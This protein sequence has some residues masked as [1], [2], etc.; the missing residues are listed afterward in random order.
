MS[1]ELPF[2]L[3]QATWKKASALQGEAS[4]GH[5]FYKNLFTDHPA[6]KETLFKG[7]NID[8]QKVNL[9]KSITTV[10]GLLT[11]MPKAVSALQQL[12][13]RHVAYD[14][15]D[16]GYAV[17]GANVI[18]TL[19]QILGSDF[20][21]EA[22]KEWITIYGV[23]EKTMIDST[24]SDKSIPFWRRLYKRRATEF[25]QMILDPA[26][27]KL[28]KFSESVSI[29]SKGNFSLVLGNTDTIDAAIAQTSTAPIRA[30]GARLAK[31]GKV[32]KEHFAVLS[33][34]IASNIPG[35]TTGANLYEKMVIDWFVTHLQGGFE[36][37]LFDDSPLGKSEAASAP[38]TTSS[39]SCNSC[40]GLNL[41]TVSCVIAAVG[42]AAWFLLK[43]KD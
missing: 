25:K 2:P 31:E 3:V 14:T 29:A 42:V 17:V 13:M 26:N 33:A 38:A 43:K 6:L 28:D 24:K 32:T 5:N 34:A 36:G 19:A 40:C 41:C 11:D 8:N 37:K 20:T 30:A 15:P 39:S 23:I 18:K 21:E 16:A 1:E 7:V 27:G 9:P 10:L 12:G 4:F 35:K 22:K